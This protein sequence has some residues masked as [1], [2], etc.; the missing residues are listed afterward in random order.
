MRASRMATPDRSDELRWFSVRCLF[1][2]GVGMYEERITVWR[3]R[4]F[5][6]AIRLAEEAAAEYVEDLSDGVVPTS[7]IG[8]AQ[9]YELVDEPGTPGAEVFSLIRDSELPPGEYIDRFFDTGT[10]HEG[11]L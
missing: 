4:D 9:A 3:A 10:E 11:D 7:Y 1:A 2:H 6:D 8:Y 5:A